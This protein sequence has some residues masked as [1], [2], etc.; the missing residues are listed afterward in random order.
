MSSADGERTAQHHPDGI[1]ERLFRRTE[2]LRCARGRWTC[3]GRAHSSCPLDAAKR[4]R[5]IFFRRLVPRYARVRPQGQGCKTRERPHSKEAESPS[6]MHA[7]VPACQCGQGE[8]RSR[9]CNTSPAQAGENFCL[10]PQSQV[11]RYLDTRRTEVL[12][13]PGRGKTSRRPGS[14]FP[15]PSLEPFWLFCFY[16]RC[17]TLHGTAFPHSHRRRCESSRTVANGFC[18][19]DGRFQLQLPC[20]GTRWTVRPHLVR[21]A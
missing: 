5:E 8:G 20:T 12:C 4:A 17:M 15:T 1:L 13:N 16:S 2:C 21:P 7:S 14:P 11:A 3:F 18:R 19:V 10:R 9:T 6:L